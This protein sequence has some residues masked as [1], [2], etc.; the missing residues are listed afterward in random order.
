MTTN[1]MFIQEASRRVSPLG[2]VFATVLSFARTFAPATNDNVIAK[3]TS[4]S[5]PQKEQAKLV[6]KGEV[7]LRIGSNDNEP[8]QF[9]SVANQYPQSPHGYNNIAGFWMEGNM[10]TGEP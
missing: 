3:A 7:W 2:A 8:P 10:L 6:F 5:V 9:I 1:G 4:Q